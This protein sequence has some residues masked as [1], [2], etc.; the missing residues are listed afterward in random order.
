MFNRIRRAVSRT[1]ERYRSKGWHRRSGTPA[2]PTA[3][4]VA[5]ADCSTARMP[6]AGSRQDVLAGEETALVRP[7]VLAAEERVTGMSALLPEGYA[8]GIWFVSAEAV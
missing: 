3:V 4:H 8:E 2:D 5:S 1:S 7:Y 6:R